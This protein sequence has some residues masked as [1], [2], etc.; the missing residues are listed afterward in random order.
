MAQD[1]SGRVWLDYAAAEPPQVVLVSK[2]G[3]VLRGWPGGVDDEVLR[4]QID[5]LAVDPR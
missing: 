1:G 2:D 3:R 4:T 5:E